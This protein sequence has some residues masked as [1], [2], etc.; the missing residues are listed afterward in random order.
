MLCNVHCSG[1]LTLGAV[2]CL[3]SCL[4]GC[5]PQVGP[6]ANFTA[7]PQSGYDPLTVGFTDASEAG[8]APIDT[9]DWSFG[10]GGWSLAQNPTHEYVASGVYPVRLTVTTAVGSDTETKTDYV[11]V[12]NA[13]ADALIVYDYEPEVAEDIADVLTDR[14]IT[15]RRLHERD[16]DEVDFDRHRVVILGSDTYRLDTTQLTLLRDSGRNVIAIG[17]GGCIIYANMGVDIGSCA[18]THSTEFV[19]AEA[20]HEVFITPNDL[21]VSDDDVLD[22][23]RVGTD[24][25]QDGAYLG[26]VPPGADVVVLATILSAAGHSSLVY[27]DERYLLWGF[28]DQF[29]RLS[30]PGADLFEN[31]V[32]YFMD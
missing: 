19:V 2:L 9:W 17:S 18:G 1:V 10:D 32:R 23:F 4:V 27:Q 22:L 26:G 5:P 8:S 15:S 14:G 11:T 13:T 24:V 7:W 30:V 28:R 29:D 6:T 25:M 20:S 12:N 16:L 31:C 21:G 3:A